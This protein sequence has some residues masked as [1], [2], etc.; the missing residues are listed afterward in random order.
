[1]S[2]KI[3]GKE[4]SMKRIIGVIAM[5]CLTAALVVSC[6]TAPAASEGIQ[7]AR[8]GVPS[9][10]LVASATDKN[11][12]DSEKAAK[13]Q[14]I[15]AI[16]SMTRNMIQAAANAGEISGDIS[17]GLQQ[18]TATALS[19]SQLN[20]AI[21]QGYG[22][23]KGKQFWTVMYMEKADIVAEINRALAAAKQITSGADS[24]NFNSRIDA[25]YQAAIART[26]SN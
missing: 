6:A 9:G 5:I 25:E 4:K 11:A 14:L 26:W 10:A 8:S 13:L 2:F 12:A 23:G 20:S 15:R 17:S 19:R 3:Q 1:M 7:K 16:T 24:F 18:G 21:R 22:E